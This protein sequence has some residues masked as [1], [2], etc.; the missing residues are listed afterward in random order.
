MQD[1]NNKT[2]NYNIVEV[3]GIIPVIWFAPADCTI[4]WGGLPEILSSMVEI[5]DNPFHI[6]IH[7]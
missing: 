6:Y 4:S 5:T 3:L 1:R 7:L 2:G